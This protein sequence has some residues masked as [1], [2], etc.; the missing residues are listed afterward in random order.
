MLDQRHRIWMYTVIEYL[1]CIFTILIVYNI[2]Q[3]IY[4]LTT[5]C[6]ASI[7]KKIMYHCEL[8]SVGRDIA[9]YMYGFPV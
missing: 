5:S 6:S 7:K 3:K 9:D 2:D 4:K 8:N 1:A